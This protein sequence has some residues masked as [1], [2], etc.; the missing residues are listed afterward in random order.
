MTTDT[1][2]V[3]LR[4]FDPR[5]GHVLRRY[6]YRGVKYVPERGWYRVTADVAAYLRTVRQDAGNPHSPPAFDVGTDEEAR[7]LEAAE[8]AKDA[9]QPA[10]DPVDTTVIEEGGTSDAPASAT[11]RGRRGEAR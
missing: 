1:M 5:R 6:T 2:L 8:A 4:P 7:A 9:K 10:S 11:G 3:R